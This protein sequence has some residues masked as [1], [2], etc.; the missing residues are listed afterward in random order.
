MIKIYCRRDVERELLPI[1]AEFRCRVYLT[2]QMRGITR[3]VRG[4][5]LHKVVNAPIA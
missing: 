2:K 3:K 1:L 5:N 4:A